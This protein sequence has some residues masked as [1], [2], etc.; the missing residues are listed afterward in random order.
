MSQLHQP[1]H[2]EEAVRRS[3]VGAEAMLGVME[4]PLHVFLKAA[5]EQHDIGLALYVAGGDAPVGGQA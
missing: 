1:T 3:P 4:P 2:A 5:E